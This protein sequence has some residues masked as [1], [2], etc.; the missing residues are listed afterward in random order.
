MFPTKYKGEIIF[1]R[2]NEKRFKDVTYHLWRIDTA[3]QSHCDQTCAHP[4]K[5]NIIM[6]Q[7]SGFLLTKKTQRQCSF[8]LEVKKVNHM[9]VM[10]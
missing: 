4:F 2:A 8:N 1:G 3:S 7:D 9:G 6:H 10:K 5:D